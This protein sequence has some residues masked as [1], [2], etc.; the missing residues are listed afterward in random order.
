MTFGGSLVRNARFGDWKCD[1]WKKSRKDVHTRVFNK[2][3]PQECPTRVACPQECPTRVSPTRVPYHKSVKQ[4]LAACFRVRVC[5][6]VRGLH[7]STCCS[8]SQPDIVV[9]SIYCVFCVGCLICFLNVC[10]VELSKGL[11]PNA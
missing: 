9:V 7:Y 1:F 2:S 10:D 4:C 11:F 6:R 8:W 5:T 3:V